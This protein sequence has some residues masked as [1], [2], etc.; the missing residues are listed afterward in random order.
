MLLLALRFACFAG[1]DPRAPCSIPRSM[2]EIWI[3]PSSRSPTYW[4]RHQFGE[5]SLHCAQIA[6]GVGRDNGPPCPR[7]RGSESLSLLSHSPEE[8]PFPRAHAKNPWETY[9]SF[10]TLSLPLL[11]ALQFSYF[12][13]S[14]AMLVSH[15]KTKKDQSIRAVTYWEVLLNMNMWTLDTLEFLHGLGYVETCGLF[16]V[17]ILG[18][19]S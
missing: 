9:K 2:N 6:R 11:R 16:N 10:S 8:R 7:H 12:L 4:I 15:G 14:I 5:K 18:T 3:P 17:L 19:P 1:L 13:W